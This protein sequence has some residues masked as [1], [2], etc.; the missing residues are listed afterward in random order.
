RLTTAPPRL[1]EI[2]VSPQMA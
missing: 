2:G 1:E